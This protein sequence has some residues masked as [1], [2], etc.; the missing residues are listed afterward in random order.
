MK[1]GFYLYGLFALVA[2]LL[3]I[4]TGCVPKFQY[5]K[6]QRQNNIVNERLNSLLAS[7]ESQK[8]DAEKWKQKFDLLIDMQKSDKDK[9]NA[10]KAALEGKNALINQLTDQMGQ[11]ALPIELS[12]DLSDWANEA[13]S[14]LVSYDERNGIVRFKSDLLFN[15]GDDTVQSEAQR[16]LESL[17]NILNTETA[18]A[19]DI[20][21]VGHTDDIPI[22]KPVTLSKHPT[23][24]HLSA[25]RS[26]SVEK[27]FAQAGIN[28]K[29]LAVLGMGE[30]RPVEP[31]LPDK[32]G[33]P[34]NRRVEIYIVPSGHINIVSQVDTSE[35]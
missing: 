34:K 22:L 25:H 26:I 18:Q 30:F 24:W 2:A 19:F 16:Q 14:D 15:K 5:D 35:N 1:G 32:K 3:L 17:S 9:I 21:I 8:L 31:N 20:L 28:Q 33:N 10:L 13:G 7:Q 11:V 6:C 29:R 4:T 23:N 12:N 27:V